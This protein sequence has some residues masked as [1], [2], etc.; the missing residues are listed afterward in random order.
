MKAGDA[1]LVLTYDLLGTAYQAIQAVQDA[2]VAELIPAAGETTLLLT[3][4]SRALVLMEESLP[5]PLSS[6]FLENVPASVIEAWLGLRNPPLQSQ[7][8]IFESEA[9]ADVFEAAIRLDKAGVVPF[10]LRILRGAKTKAYVMATGET[11]ALFL[12]DLNGT[13]T[14]I[15][16]P[17][18]L[19]RDF[20]EIAPNR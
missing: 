2:D 17:S 20:F 11:D 1:L 9:I 10:D 12:Q 19:L 8:A 15:P 5:R 3:G 6:R 4:A 14:M 7:F 18:P 13:L 16:G